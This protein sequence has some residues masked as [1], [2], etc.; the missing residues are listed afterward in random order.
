M[1]TRKELKHPAPGFA[2]NLPPPLCFTVPCGSYRASGIPAG[3][4]AHSGQPR[5]MSR[6]PHLMMD[7]SD[8]STWQRPYRFTR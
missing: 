1:I 3:A 8:P 4:R 7:P 5:L 6:K 2:T